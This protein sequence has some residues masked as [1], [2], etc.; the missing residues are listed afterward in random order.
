[1][2]SI[3]DWFR[4]LG[5]SAIVQSGGRW[6]ARLSFRTGVVVAIVC[7]LC[8][9][10][11]FAQ[12]LLPMSAAAKGVLWVVLFGMAKTAQYTAILIL[13]KEGIVRLRRILRREPPDA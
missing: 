9:V 2:K 3:R 1:M 7:A 13:G 6:L 8:Y 11:S 12:M 10:A 4:S 5:R